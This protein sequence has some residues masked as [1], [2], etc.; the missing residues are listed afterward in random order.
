MK[1]FMVTPPPHA[2]DIAYRTGEA[3]AQAF[4]EALSY[5]PFTGTELSDLVASYLRSLPAE[6]ENYLRGYLHCIQQALSQG[7]HP[8]EVVEKERQHG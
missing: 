1:R 4:I 6:A 7:D 2:H 3:H 5:A 8:V